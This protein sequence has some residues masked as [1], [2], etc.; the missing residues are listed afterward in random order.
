M[1][2]P[3]FTAAETEAAA[4]R[5]P[6]ARD[7]LR[8][9]RAGVPQG[10]SPSP[11]PGSP[12]RAI[13]TPLPGSL[14]SSARAVRLA[15]PDAPRLLSDVTHNK[16]NDGSQSRCHLSAVP[17]DASDPTPPRLPGSRVPAKGRALGF[18]K[19]GLWRS[20]L[21]NLRRPEGAFGRFRRRGAG[22]TVA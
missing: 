19:C 13:A 4:H 12:G 21:D 17:G 5:R 8:A 11:E 14:L 2:E 6:D 10:R 18:S 20:A 15:L 16:G 1:G 22:L 3:H 9:R 7:S